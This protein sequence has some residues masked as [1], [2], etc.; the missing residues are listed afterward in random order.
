MSEIEELLR[1]HTVGVQSALS[2]F[3][4]QLTTLSEAVA[5][6]R[7]EADRNGS[8]VT[9]ATSQLNLGGEGGMAAP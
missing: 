1:T 9:P 8:T 2:G 5:A 7:A 3:E 6:I 4:G